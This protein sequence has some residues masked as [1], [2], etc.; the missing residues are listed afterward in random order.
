MIEK[1]IIDKE[2]DIRL[3][4]NLKT[5]DGRVANGSYANGIITINPN[6]NRAGEFIAIH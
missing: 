3:D 1:I 2:I 5:L 4:G 6:S